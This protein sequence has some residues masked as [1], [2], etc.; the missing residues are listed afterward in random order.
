MFEECDF[1]GE[2]MFPVCIKQG[3]AERLYIRWGLYVQ[4][5]TT[6]TGV[7]LTQLG[8]LWFYKPEEQLTS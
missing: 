3:V 1:I 8:S 6:W 4:W 2:K 7:H 5:G